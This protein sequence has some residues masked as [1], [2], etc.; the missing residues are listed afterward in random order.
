[1]LSSTMLRRVYARSSQVCKLASSTLPSSSTNL[2]TDLALPSLSHYTCFSLVLPLP[3]T[4]VPLRPRLHP[5]R[6]TLPLNLNLN[7]NLDPSLPCVQAGRDPDLSAFLHLNAAPP[8][9]PAAAATT[10]NAE[11]QER[12]RHRPG[13]TPFNVAAL[14]ALG[15]GGGLDDADGESSESSDGSP[16]RAVPAAPTSGAGAGARRLSA[17]PERG[18]APAG[19]PPAAEPRGTVWLGSADFPAP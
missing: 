11:R 15:G 6:P 7:L 2:P 3:P 1:M 18:R 16:V 4:P 5:S 9:N 13:P 19:P 17:G 8:L 12:L 10:T 14:P